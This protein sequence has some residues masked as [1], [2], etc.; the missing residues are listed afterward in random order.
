[1]VGANSTQNSTL[2]EKAGKLLSW[3][4]G[5]GRRTRLKMVGAN[6]TQNS[7]LKEKGL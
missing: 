6:S 4:G 1:M 7:T 2:K 5:T 3:S